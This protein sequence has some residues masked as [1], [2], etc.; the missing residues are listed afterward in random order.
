MNQQRTQGLALI[1]VLMLVAVLAA[2]LA[3][4]FA[5]T[6]SETRTGRASAASE[7]GFY[8][9]EGGLN[10][11]AEALRAKFRG[12]LRPVGTSPAAS[13]ACTGANVGTDDLACLTYTIGGRRVVTWVE[14]RSKFTG[15]LPESGIVGPGEV[16]TGMAYQQYAF[17]VLA[18]S[19]HPITGAREAR[20]E[21][22]FQSRLVPLFQF[23]AFYNDDLEFHPGS[24]MSVTGRVHTNGNLHLNAGNSVLSSS[25]TLDILGKTSAAGD[26]Y[27]YDK[28]GRPCTGQVRVTGTTLGCNSPQAAAFTPAQLTS[29]GGNLLSRQDKLTVPPMSTLAPGNAD[30]D[31]WTLADLRIQAVQLTPRIGTRGNA[32]YVAPTFALRVLRP[33]GAVDTTATNALTACNAASP[34]AVTTRGDTFWDAREAKWMSLIDIHQ[35]RLMDCIGSGTLP[36][37]SLGDTT[38]GGLSWHFSFEDGNPATNV[39][40]ETN[41][42]VLVHDAARLGSTTSGTEIKGLTITTN[43]ALYTRGDYNTVNKKPA[44][45]IGDAINVLSNALNRDIVQSDPA[46]GPPASTTTVQAAV[47]SGIDLTVPGVSYNGGYQ[48][49]FRLHENWNGQT[50]SYRGSVVSLG[51]SQHMRGPQS[52]ARYDVPVRDWKYDGDF[53][54]PDRLPPLTPRFVYLRQLL[55][56]RNF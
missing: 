56:A 45:L 39:A 7:A 23:A 38:G 24:A 29:F 35:G 4:Y 9:A 16:F 33:S 49:Y 47:L 14:D 36:G 6:M 41:Y 48:N 37:V 19:Y 10:L 46:Y 22:V 44:A 43:Q 26:V 3:A 18:E 21:M 11:R 8:S 52:R 53:D 50:L 31:L 5:M 40:G 42:G 25:A 28:D 20:T 13:G 34:A 2:I 1:T 15:G 27:R 51:Q 55:F 32:G 54:N 12:Y 30:S 17:R